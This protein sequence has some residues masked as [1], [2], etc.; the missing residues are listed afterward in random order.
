MKMKFAV[1][2]SVLLNVLI[3]ACSSDL[4]GSSTLD[5]SVDSILTHTKKNTFNLASSAMENGGNLPVA[6]TCDG[7][8][9]SPPVS[10][11]GAPEGTQ[12][13]ALIMHHVAGPEDTHWYWLMYNISANVSHIKSGEVKGVLGNNSVNRLNKYAPPCSKEPGLKAYTLTLYALSETVNLKSIADVDRGAL[14]DAIKDR[15]LASSELVVNYERRSKADSERCKSIK[16]SVDLAGFSDS[17]RVT[18]DDEFAFISSNTYPEHDL[19]NGI[20]GTNEQIPVPALQYSAPIKLT[21]KTADELTTIDAALGVAVNGVPIYDYS[22]QGELDV[23]NYNARKD[24]ILLGQLDNCGGH[25]G[26]GDDY[27]YHASPDCMIN[28]M[29]NAA[30]EPII[31]WAYDGYP[32]Y[33]N[34]NPDGSS[35][36]DNDL[37]VCN[38]QVD[39]TFGYRYHTSSK[40]PYIIQCLIGEVDTHTLPR[41]PPLSSDNPSARADLRPPHNGVKNLTH[42]ITQDGSRRMTYEHDGN[43]YYVNYRPSNTQNNCYDFE[44]KTVSNGGI[45]ETGEFCRVLPKKSTRPPRPPRRPN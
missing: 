19:M 17:V 45:I 37:G 38:G 24:T 39:D 43:H 41:V 12:E 30:N 5:T 18:C 23:H 21:P 6:Y 32:I 9:I 4:D 35:I 16:Q 3:S 2:I 15:T 22:A 34:N 44:Q 7:G 14:L 28:V 20:T 26:R 11:N 42:T 33:G 29:S 36:A 40:P 13:Y 1:V 27:H 31:G 25:A 8:S 10:W